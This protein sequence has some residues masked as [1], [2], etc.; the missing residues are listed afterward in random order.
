MQIG[1]KVIDAVAK[2]EGISLSKLQEGAAAG[3]GR[4][5]GQ[6]VVLAKPMTFMNNSGESVRKLVKFYK[7]ASWSCIC[8]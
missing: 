7:V 3:R 8:A 1:F 6:R 2:A 5:A 4:I